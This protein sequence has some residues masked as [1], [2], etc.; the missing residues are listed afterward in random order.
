[1]AACTRTVHTGIS[2]AVPHLQPPRDMSASS[3][4][5]RDMASDLYEW[6]SLVSLQSPRLE[7][8]DDIDPYLSRY[9]PPSPQG[10]HQEPQ[11]LAQMTWQGFMSGAVAHD[12]LITVLQ[13]ATPQMWFSI[14][15]N[16]FAG[17]LAVSCKDC[18]ILK[19]PGPSNE[20][21]LWEIDQ[22]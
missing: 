15:A 19:L 12:T 14:S 20:Y 21:M 10:G 16:S 8:S 5:F 9:T 2:L 11:A 6:L 3:D 4:D 17:N 13:K 18:T 22:E 7:A 1:M